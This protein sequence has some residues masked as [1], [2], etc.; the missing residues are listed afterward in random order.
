M[1]AILRCF[2]AA[3]AVALVVVPGAAQRIPMGRLP[4]EARCLGAPNATTA[5]IGCRGVVTVDSEEGDN[6]QEDDDLNRRTCS[7]L[8]PVVES[9]ATGE[10]RVPGGE[11]IEIQIIPRGEPYV[12]QARENRVLDSLIIFRGIIGAEVCMRLIYVHSSV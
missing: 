11:C 3:M 9:I 7:E 8:E 12:V 4:A 2:A 10:T 1:A 5:C 6:C